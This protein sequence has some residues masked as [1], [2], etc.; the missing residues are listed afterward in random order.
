MAGNCLSQA[1]RLTAFSN[2]ARKC[3]VRDLNPGYSLGKAMSYQLDQHRSEITLVFAE[4][5][6]FHSIAV[7]LLPVF[8]PRIEI[9]IGEVLDDVAE[10][11]GKDQD[12]RPAE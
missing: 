12:Y 11:A 4:L 9:L 1:G 5:R 3:G 10:H 6:P 8:D 7:G 2:Y